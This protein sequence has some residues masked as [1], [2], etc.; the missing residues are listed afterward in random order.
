MVP[1]N[2]RICEGL[3]QGDFNVNFASVC[4]PKLVDEDHEL[5]GERRDSTE[6]TRQGLFQ[7]D[8]RAALRYPGQKSVSV[9]LKHI[10][11]FHLVLPRHRWKGGKA[12]AKRIAVL[13][14]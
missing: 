6:F 3:T 14:G 4:L 9:R 13:S 5:V 1:M 7:L 10:F 12:N 2:H 11:R 8:I